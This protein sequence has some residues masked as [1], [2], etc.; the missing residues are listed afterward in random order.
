MSA[1]FLG[2]IV[3][4]AI[5]WV[6]FTYYWKPNQNITDFGNNDAIREEC[7]KERQ[8]LLTAL[9]DKDRDISHLRARVANLQEVTDRVSPPQATTEQTAVIPPPAPSPKT[10]PTPPK[11]SLSPAPQPV[12]R[13]APNKSVSGKNDLKRISGIGPKISELLVAENID[14]LAVLAKTDLSTL[15]SILEKAGTRYATADP[16]SW[17]D[18]AELLNNGDK[19]GH[20]KLIDTLKK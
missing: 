14:S 16:S 7:E 8:E 12:T 20:A 2:I 10:A 5:E 6:F 18:Q 3:G 15:K 13:P 1:F 17:P 9:Q 4:W 19:E 11:D